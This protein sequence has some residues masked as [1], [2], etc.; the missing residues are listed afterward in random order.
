MRNYPQTMPAEFEQGAPSSG[1]SASATFQHYWHVLLERRWMIVFIMFVAVAA[2]LAYI[3]KAPKVYLATTRIQIDPEAESRISLRETPGRSGGV[4]QEYLQT[5]YRNLLSRRLLADVVKQEELNEDSRYRKELD[6]AKALADDIQISPIRMTRLVDIGVEH[7]NPRKAASIANTLADKF[8]EANKVMLRQ[9]TM[10]TL[11]TLRSQS[12]SLERDVTEAEEKVQEYRDRHSN[13]ATLDVTDNP[14]AQALM[15]AQGGVASA[16]VIA[17]TAQAVVKALEAHIE[18]GKPLET[19]PAI[20]E[21]ARISQL[22]MSLAGYETELSGLRQTYKD[23]HPKIIDVESRIA[24]TRSNLLSFAEIIRKT[25]TEKADLERAKLQVHD[26]NLSTWAGKQQEWNKVKT[27]YDVLQRKA[28]ASRALFNIVLSRLEESEFM[29]TA[30]ANMQSN[31]NVVDPATIPTEPFKPRVPLVLLGGVLG[32]LVLAV[33]LALF[34]NLLDDSIKTQDDVELHLQVPFLGYVPS[35]KNSKVV[36][37]FLQSH[38]RPQ[39]NAAESFRS[40]RAA[41]AL[42]DHGEKLRAFSVTSTIPSEGK[43][44]VAAN[45][46]IVMAQTGLRTLLVDADLRRPTLHKAFQVHSPLG[47]PA[48]LTGKTTE[49]DDLIHHSEVSNLDLICSD[50]T[51]SQSTELV[52]SKSMIRFLEEVTKRYDRVVLDC[53]PVSAVSDALVVSALVDGTIFVA[54]FNKVR[55]DHA[56]KSIR[57]LTDAGVRI[58]GALLN[59]IDFEG[60]DSYYYSYYHYQNRYYSSYRRP[61]AD[62]R[63]SA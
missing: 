24:E 4:D 25:L 38:L 50:A 44:V 17:D 58:C 33:G 39:S 14:I 7:P 22:Q 54:K 12:Q 8:I 3:Y 48:Y 55:R 59:D 28:E 2:S 49:V 42:G 46:A 37:R 45:V 53:P 60:R 30:S 18:A 23:K 31:I 43:S 57:R 32:G 19:F 47:L 6:L 27:E 20:A 1:A 5:Q 9:R 15:Q 56:R 41:V 61:R 63:E 34:I 11:N 26:Q 40:I 35:I 62:F 51:A 52:A 10:G 16:T 29:Q 21:D 36:E 13:F